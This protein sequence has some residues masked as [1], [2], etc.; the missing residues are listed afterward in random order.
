M[1]RG[2]P[3]KDL[4]PRQ[5]DRRR[6]AEQIKDD[7]PRRHCFGLEVR[8]SIDDPDALGGGHG[9][10]VEVIIRPGHALDAK[11][12]QI[13]SERPCLVVLPGKG[14]VSTRTPMTTVSSFAVGAPSA[15]A[16]AVAAASVTV[17]SQS[18]SQAAA[19][20]IISQP[21]QSGPAPEPQ[22]E[23]C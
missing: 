3:E 7:M 9:N 20:R 19:A 10:R 6:I 22:L 11:I 8:V 18:R 2:R 17:T 16:N 15:A 23:P 13:T 1:G 21:R 14:G 5:T 12:V 4:K